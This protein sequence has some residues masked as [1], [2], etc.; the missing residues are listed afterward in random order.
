MGAYRDIKD[1]KR[2]VKVRRTFEPHPEHAAVYDE[3]YGA[4]RQAYPGLS[5]LGK[6]LNR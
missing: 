5:R 2:V 3:L 6:A 4:F 1:L